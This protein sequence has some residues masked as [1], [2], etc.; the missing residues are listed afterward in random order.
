MPGGAGHGLHE[1]FFF[2]KKKVQEGGGGGAV[3]SHMDKAQGRG[4]GIPICSIVF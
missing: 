2:S 3:A 4:T 1:D